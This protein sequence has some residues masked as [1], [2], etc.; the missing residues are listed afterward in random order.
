MT[1]FDLFLEVLR[2]R[3][4]PPHDL[5]IR[6][7][8]P[9]SMNGAPQA[10][11]TILLREAPKDA[12]MLIIKRAERAG[13]PWSGHLALPGGRADAGDANLMATAA[14]ET[15]EEVGINL[16]AG[17]LEGGHFVGALPLLDTRNPRLPDLEIRPFV[18]VAPERAAARLSEEVAALYWVS[19]AGLRRDGA[20]IEYKFKDGDLILKRPAY[21]SAGGP[22]WGI[23]ERILTSFLS[24]LD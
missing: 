19:V 6:A 22:I 5:P 1:H 9:G 20:S 7:I 12:E 11:V 13:D 21:P 3:L 2:E 24:F 8:R 18:A 4:A 15:W 14:R 16:E 10:A 17:P 23:T